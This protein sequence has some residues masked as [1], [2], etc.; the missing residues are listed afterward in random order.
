[1]ANL[2]EYIQSQVYEN[3]TEDISGSIM[4]QVLTRM[5]SDEGVVN[6]HTISGQTP[7]AD[8]NNAQAARGAVPDGFKKLGLIITYKLSSGW[9]IDEFIGSA[10]S[11]WSTASNWKCLGPISVSQNASTGKTTITIGSQ[12]YDVATQPVSVSQNTETGKT[13]L[14]IGN[15]PALIVDN[16]P[17]AGS[18]NLVKSGGV[19]DALNGITSN[20]YDNS[21]L[22][23]AEI[24][25]GGFVNSGNGQI[26]ENAEWCYT[27]YIAIKPNTDYGPIVFCAWYDENKVYISGVLDADAGT[28]TS[29]SNAKYA[30]FSINLP[31]KESW[32]IAE[33]GVVVDGWQKKIFSKNLIKYTTVTDGGFIEASNGQVVSEPNWCYT[34]FIPIT[35]LKYY[36]KL[37]MA[38]WYDYN[39]TYISGELSAEG[40]IG[41]A[42]SNAAYLRASMSISN[43]DNW[44]IS[45]N[46]EDDTLEGEILDNKIRINELEAKEEQ[47]NEFHVG[48]GY[49][50]TTFSAAIAAAS[51]V[52]TPIVYVHSGTYDLI[53]ENQAKASEGH[54]LIVIEKSMKIVFEPNAK[55]TALFPSSYE[56]YT[57]CSP[58]HIIG[59]ADVTFEGMNIECSNCLYCVHDESY[60]DYTYTHKFINCNMKYTTQHSDGVRQCI[61]GGLGRF[62]T[63]IIDGGV[64]ES[65]TSSFD[66]QG[67]N[68]LVISYHNG[69]NNS[70]NKSVIY[71]K[72]LYLKHKGRMEFYHCGHTEIMTDVYVCNCSMGADVTI[73]QGSGQYY[74]VDNM[75]LFAWNN[76]VRNNY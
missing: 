71:V 61:G 33:G 29:P 53:S 50:Y 46:G 17:E 36:G 44:S 15:N 13:E 63:I 59:N 55:L 30:R 65:D 34:D 32:A 8:Y 68:E 5:A 1:M 64:Y 3:S 72:D 76:V 4:Q 37:N 57:E 16:E 60:G 42:P 52:E 62:C 47:R 14:L 40:V 35:A 27:D 45:E 2:I 73:P 20:I 51:L 6:V 10:T 75:Q 70:D 24:T 48:T 39:K 67:E 74:F 25:D 49:E 22:R 66:S 19:H 23:G 28:H 26:E 21:I 54:N 12:S 58:I 31:K 41:Q 7:F 43:K 9:Y 11:G 18:D 69:V 56:Y 38:A